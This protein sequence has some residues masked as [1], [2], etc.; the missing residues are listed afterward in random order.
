MITENE[1]TRTLTFDERF[2]L[3]FALEQ[4]ARQEYWGEEL[5]RLTG[6]SNDRLRILAAAMTMTE[7]I[8][9][10]LWPEVDVNL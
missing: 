9:V 6:L 4:I 8:D 7:R 1:R 10:I 2:A 3:Q 5:R